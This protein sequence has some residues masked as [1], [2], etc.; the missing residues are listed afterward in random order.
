M[1]IALAFDAARQ[2][3]WRSIFAGLHLEALAAVEFV[4]V[5]S[6]SELLAAEAEIVVG[7]AGGFVA[8][9]LGNAPPTLRWAHFMNAGV[10]PVSKALGG[11]IPA[12]LASN[13]RGIHAGPMAEFVLMAML[14]FAKRVPLWTE[15]QRRHR[16]QPAAPR[17][18]AGKTAL[19]VGAG[20]I[21]TG[22]A[23][24]CKALGMQVIGVATREG[25]R[26][27]FDRIVT[28]MHEPLSGADFVV[29]SLPLTADTHQMFDRPAFAAMKRGA[30]FVNIGR[31]EMVDEDAI[32]EVLKSGQ[33]GGAALDAHTT[34]PLPETS[35]LWDAPNLLLTPHVSGRYDGGL[36]QGAELFAENFRRYLAGEPLATPV[37]LSRGY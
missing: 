2:A 1:R 10:D 8:S 27:H 3:E 19:I 31:G 37:D 18:L 28:S 12:F 11:Q 36:V 13:V 14:H 9:F 32:I 35:P 6:V 7:Y 20:S 15:L 26:P 30:V 24:A 16:W 4:S 5:R 23:R 25:P 21:G 22:T 29:C 17:M 34:E 33:L